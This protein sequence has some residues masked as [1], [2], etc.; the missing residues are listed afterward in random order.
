MQT[1]SFAVW[2]SWCP[3]KQS[4][5]VALIYYRVKIKVVVAV[6]TVK[7]EC[8]STTCKNGGTC[9]EIAVGRHLCTCRVGFL[10]ENCEGKYIIW[11][12]LSSFPS[13]SENKPSLVGFPF[14][15]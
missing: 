7:K 5:P 2:L 10:G 12:L 8:K 3:Y 13:V 4:K 15:I 14:L 6:V 9:T 11:H 1:P